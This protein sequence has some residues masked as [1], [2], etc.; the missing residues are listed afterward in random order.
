[1]RKFLI[2]SCRNQCYR[3][4]KKET[5]LLANW[6]KWKPKKQWK[7]GSERK[8]GI[9][10][11]DKVSSYQILKEGAINCLRKKQKAIKDTVDEATEFEG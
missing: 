11:C 1:M 8:K 3:Y 10:H 4:Y 5:L 2:I 9:Q 6:G 7:L